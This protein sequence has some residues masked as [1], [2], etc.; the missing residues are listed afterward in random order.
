MIYLLDTNVC[1]YTIKGKYPYLADKIKS[2]SPENIKISA[3]T[4]SEL[5]YGCC[6]SNFPNK[7]IDAVKKFISPFE[8]INFDYHDAAVFGNIRAELEIKGQVIGP[9]DMQLAA[10]TISRD[11]IIVT[12][13][14][15]E[16]ERI[17]N[18]KIENWIK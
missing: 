3:I 18:L 8:V 6:K 1:I 9:Y 11:Y 15:R 14:T 10:Q 5:M 17:S 2:F 4:V 12:N 13:N 16:F 7:N